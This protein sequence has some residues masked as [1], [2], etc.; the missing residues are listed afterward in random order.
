[1]PAFFKSKKANQYAQVARFFAYSSTVLM[2][3]LATVLINALLV[4][5]P[6]GTPA[7]PTYKLAV[8]GFSLLLNFALGEYFSEK[9]K[10]RH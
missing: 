9:G 2:T 7:L 8:I 6:A 5:V 3:A 10:T 1:M 4:P